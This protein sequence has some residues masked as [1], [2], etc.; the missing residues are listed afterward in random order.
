V[1]YSIAGLAI[2]PA[3]KAG[4]PA[5]LSQIP[6]AVPS[7]KVKGKITTSRATKR[8]T[9]QVKRL[10]K[11]GTDYFTISGSVPAK[12]GSYQ[13]YRAVSNPSR[14]SGELLKA[15]L[16]QA[17]V[18]VKGNVEV[19]FKP[20]PQQAELLLQFKGAPL[21]E[22]IGKVLTFSNN[23]MADMLAIKL[24]L[25]EHAGQ[26]NGSTNLLTEAG[27]GLEN[28]LTDLTQSSNGL[29]KV[30]LGQGDKDSLLPIVMSG[31]GLTPANRLSATDIVSVL[32]HIYQQTD[33]FP[34]FLAG[35]VVPNNSKR[36]IFR[37]GSDDWLKRIQVKTGSLTQP[38][39]VFGLAGY[40]R[41]RNG[42]WGA[43]AVI[44]NG[45]ANNKQQTYPELQQA[46]KAD[47]EK[48]LDRF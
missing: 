4:Q 2:I 37:R 36:G 32:A 6:F 9:F 42:H 26:T 13:V 7:I 47:M 8:P 14:Y 40:L 3:K 20:V 10:T 29:Q 48:L 22:Q 27:L 43:F 17:G 44:T 11:A 30:T 12:G 38:R 21:K 34:S 18:T 35:L 23:Y 1:N 31:S 15:F 39:P 19:S 41:L 16:Q 25:T 46:V 24:W 33:L 28:Y 5:R 45:L